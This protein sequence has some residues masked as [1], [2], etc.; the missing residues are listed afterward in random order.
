MPNWAARTDEI[1]R[2]IVA[3]SLLSDQR[4]AHLA[5]LAWSGSVDHALDLS[6]LAR[7][8]AARESEIARLDRE[9]VALIGKVERTIS[10]G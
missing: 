8:I 7:R 2:A 10:R 6:R 9:L 1:T 4:F 3:E 5:P